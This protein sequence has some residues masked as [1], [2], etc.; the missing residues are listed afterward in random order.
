M[1]QDGN[2]SCTLRGSPLAGSKSIQLLGGHAVELL[3]TIA[4]PGMKSVLIATGKAS[5]CMICVVIYPIV[6]STCSIKLYYL[7]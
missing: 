3:E 5:A 2:L 6:S 1:P 4:M 7:V